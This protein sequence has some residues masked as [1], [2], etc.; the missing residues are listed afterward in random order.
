MKA[1]KTSKDYSSLKRWLEKGYKIICFAKYKVLPEENIFIAS[2]EA[3][4]YISIWGDKAY[5]IARDQCCLL[6]LPGNITNEVFS[7]VCEALDVEFIEPNN[8]N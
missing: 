6:K 8:D 5:F 1:Y 2:M 4:D 3:P 7:K